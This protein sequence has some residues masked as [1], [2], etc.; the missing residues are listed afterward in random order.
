MPYKS[1]GAATHLHAPNVCRGSVVPCW[2]R[3]LQQVAFVRSKFQDIPEIR[4][5][6]DR[7]VNGTQNNARD[8]AL[9]FE[10]TFPTFPGL[11]DLPRP[12]TEHQ[13]GPVHSRGVSPQA[14]L[15]YDASGPNDPDHW[16]RST[17]DRQE[18]EHKVP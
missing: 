7:I 5:V 16:W 6:A 9:C 11:M 4:T 13:E 2:S 8:C 18:V 17:H 10:T 15:R 14:I 3:C 12:R 1:P